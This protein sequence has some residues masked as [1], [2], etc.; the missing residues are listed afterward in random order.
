MPHWAGA[1]LPSLIVIAACLVLAWLALWR[2]PRPW[3]WPNH[4]LTAL[5]RT[6]MAAVAQGFAALRNGRSGAELLAL[7]VAVWFT[8][9]L[10]NYLLIRAF[11]LEVPWL[12][13]AVVLMILQVGISLPS[14]PATLGLFEYLVVLA[15][16]LF[17]VDD[18]TA[19]SY[20]LLLHAIVLLP[21]FIG[22]WLFWERGL[23]LVHFSRNEGLH[24]EPPTT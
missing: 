2:G 4:R 19:L 7:S 1:A 12:A 14:A 22:A 13:A 23:S 5:V 9:V 18:N 17:G 3:R 11:N 16:S 6:R 21:T 15:L 20:G 24:L 8:S 10:N